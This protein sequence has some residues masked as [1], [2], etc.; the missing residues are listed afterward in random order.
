M[1]DITRYL[2]RLAE[3][4]GHSAL[5]ARSGLGVSFQADA[6]GRIES[7]TFHEPPD[8]KTFLRESGPPAEDLPTVEDVLAL[9]G[10]AARVA[11]REA[12][13]GT[14]VT[15]TVWVPQAGVRGTVT[16]YVR[17]TD[18][19]AEHIDFGRF[20]RI[21]VVAAG[22]RAWTYNPVR[23]LVA[24]K[25]DELAHA[26]LEHPAAVE[27]DWRDYF[28]S[29]EVLRN[30]VLDDRPVHVVRLRGRGL[31]GRTYWVDAETGDVLKL[32]QIAIEGPLRIPVAVTFSEFREVGG[33]RRAT[34]IESV[35][36]E[37]GR[38]VIAF[39]EFE[40]GLEL[41]D[42]VFTLPDPED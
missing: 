29:V 16:V 42:G 9:R 38:T 12:A 20:G 39:E 6:E 5:R 26:L 33:I 34:R 15:G 18:H 24:L 8:E 36:R 11:A 13:G 23:G 28:D 22:E 4:E 30:D 35:N 37:S 25:G 3:G 41:G 31:P 40:T 27:G 10:T 14:R 19:R 7:F 2:D 21:D 32:R 17:G 1:S